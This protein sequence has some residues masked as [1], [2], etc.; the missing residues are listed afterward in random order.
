[1]NE[2]TQSAVNEFAGSTN[3]IQWVT[4]TI[5][6]AKQAHS[7]EYLIHAYQSANY[8]RRLFFSACSKVVNRY[9]SLV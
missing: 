7:T 5:D 9:K 2:F 6:R 1:M 4:D 3:T 8:E